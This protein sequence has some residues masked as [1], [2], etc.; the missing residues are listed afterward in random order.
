MLD[1]LDLRIISPFQLDAYLPELNKFIKPLTLNTSPIVDLRKFVIDLIS[2]SILISAQNSSNKKSCRGYVTVQDTSAV[3]C[4]N[5]S[6]VSL[7]YI[8]LTLSSC[9]S[10]LFI[11]TAT[12]MFPKMT[13]ILLLKNSLQLRTV[14]MYM[15][16]LA[17]TLI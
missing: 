16:Q 5:K 8:H 11:T 10:Y 12:E 14:R 3:Y 9:P 6:S 7:M 15:K 1:H 17:M 4:G 13:I 2:F